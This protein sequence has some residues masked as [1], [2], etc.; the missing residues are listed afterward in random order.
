MGLLVALTITSASAQKQIPDSVIND[1]KPIQSISNEIAKLDFVA[2]VPG[3]QV[4]NDN[5]AVLLRS[6]LDKLSIEV[7]VF[8]KKYENSAVPWCYIICAAGQ[9]VCEQDCNNPVLT[10]QQK[11]TCLYSCQYAMQG[12]IW[13][14]CNEIPPSINK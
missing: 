13:R 5:D 8:M 10:P 1:F 7:S 3:W 9:V 6:L 4:S 11:A 12:C 2:N 14:N